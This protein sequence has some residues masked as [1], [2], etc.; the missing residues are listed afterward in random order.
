MSPYI[1]VC[2]FLVLSVGVLRPQH[3]RLSGKPSWKYQ[4]SD[5]EN[6][7]SGKTVLLL[8]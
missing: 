8:T 3:G 2:S 1:R 7:L 4:G 5:K 6:V